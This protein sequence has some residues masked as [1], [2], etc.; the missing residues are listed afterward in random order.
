[1]N[2]HTTVAMRT[3][4][5]AVLGVTVLTGCSAPC[6]HAAEIPIEVITLGTYGLACGARE[7]ARAVERQVADVGVSVPE[8]D[9]PAAQRYS[10]R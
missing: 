8:G 9:D 7:N 6:W 2:T 5:A 3:A 1:M 4:V 10:G